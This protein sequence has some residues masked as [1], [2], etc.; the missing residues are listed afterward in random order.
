MPFIKPLIKTVLVSSLVFLVI[1]ILGSKYHWAEIIKFKHNEEVNLTFPSEQEEQKS[2][3]HQINTKQIEKLEEIEEKFEPRLMSNVNYSSSVSLMSK[4]Q[5]SQ[6]CQ[7]LFSDSGMDELL[8]DLAI[9]DCVVSNY[10]E[11]IQEEA[12]SNNNR[13]SQTVKKNAERICTQKLKQKNDSH[14]VLEQQLLI[15]ICVSDQL[16]RNKVISD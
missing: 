13:Q 6:K 1:V 7:Q 10:N 8:L 14:T 4:E 5:V 11:T 3:S 12:E 15:G 9:G 16:N 2:T